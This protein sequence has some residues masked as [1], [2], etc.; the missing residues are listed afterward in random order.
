MASLDAACRA[1]HPRLRAG[2][3][4]AADPLPEPAILATLMLEQLDALGRVG[5]T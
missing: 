1:R 3:L 2:S 4:I 5:D